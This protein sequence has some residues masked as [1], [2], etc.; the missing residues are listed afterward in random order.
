V[1]CFV[2]GDPGDERVRSFGTLAHGH[3][4]DV[5]EVDYR[6]LLADP[7]EALREVT[8]DD[9][10]RLET[11]GRAVDLTTALV[12]HGAAERTAEG[13]AALQGAALHELTERG[14]LLANRQWFLGYRRLLR[15]LALRIAARGGR[16][17][18]P[19]EDVITMFDKPACHA[20]L[21]GAG[22]AVPRA[23]GP[24]AGFESLLA[25]MDEAR[26]GRV[27]VKLAH[28]SA[29]AGVVALQ[30]G[31]LGFQAWT[32]VEVDAAARRGQIRLYNT[33]RIRHLTRA[34]EVAVV[35]DTLAPEGLQ[36]EQWIP[37]AS[38]PGGVVDLRAA[39]L[40]GAVAA[41]VARVARSPISNLH[42]GNRREDA[43]EVASRMGPAAWDRLLATVAAVANSFPESAKL[44]VDVAVTSGWRS[45]AVLEVNAF[46]DYLKDVTWEG[47]TTHQREARL[48]SQ[49]W[50]PGWI[51]ARAA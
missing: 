20:R 23:L 5:R 1:R 33:R 6:S 47:E 24:V 17:L 49:G 30:R 12:A 36:V 32:T 44:A 14:R 42:L 40:G 10:I 43:G 51:G 41:V 45:H 25:A 11:P 16:F 2:V 50:R 28:G 22:V 9:L 15:D 48:L 7:E 21:A 35:V 34:S 38:L 4:L 18:T 19:P 27:F 8:A 13:G 46:G 37:R 3:G 29:G 39:W 26:V 31:V